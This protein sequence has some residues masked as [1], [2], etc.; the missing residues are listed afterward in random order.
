MRTNLIEEQDKRLL[1]MSPEREDI[2]TNNNQ[3]DL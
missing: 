2:N 1:L 3:N